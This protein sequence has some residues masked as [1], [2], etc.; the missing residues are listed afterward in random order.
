MYGK[1]TRD[2]K[3]WTSLIFYVHARLSHV[4]SFWFTHVILARNFRVNLKFHMWNYKIAMA[5]FRTSQ[6]Q[7]G[8]EVLKCREWRYQGTKRQKTWTHE[9]K[10]GKRGI[11]SKNCENSE[12]EPNLRSKPWESGGSIDTIQDKHVKIHDC[13]RNSSSMI[14]IRDQLI[15]HTKVYARSHGK[16]TRHWKSTL[17]RKKAIFAGHILLCLVSPRNNVWGTGLLKVHLVVLLISWSIFAAWHNQSE[18]PPRSGY[19]SDTSSVWYF[20]AC[21]LEVISRSNQSPPYS[22]S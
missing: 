6:C 1:V 18:T 9:S 16:I 13:W 12:L 17:R 8:D 2:R 11:L 19:I 10:R 4:A 22:L 7:D 15:T 20:C 3:S 21:S 5:T 14:L